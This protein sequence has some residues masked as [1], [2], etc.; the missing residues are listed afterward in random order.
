MAIT[1]Q[2]RIFLVDDDPSFHVFLKDL[3]DDASVELC[4]SATG[5]GAMR[6]LRDGVFDLLLIDNQLPDMLG[7]EILE[8]LRDRE[9]DTPSVMVTGHATVALAVEAMKLGASDVFCKPIEEPDKLLRF[10]NRTLALDPPLPLSQPHLADDT[11]SSSLSGDFSVDTREL[12]RRAV[13]VCPELTEREVEVL[14][15]I[16]SGLSNK[17]IG[18]ALHISERTVKNHTSSIYRKFS[19]DSRPKLFLRMLEFSRGGRKE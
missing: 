16:V 4:Y 7:V 19:V 10:I 1:E 3:L 6:E 18:G 9:V 17:E 14:G 13:K 5:A 12:I 15:Q 8:W 11:P 2:T